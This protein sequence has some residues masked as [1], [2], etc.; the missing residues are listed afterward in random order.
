MAHQRR[1]ANHAVQRPACSMDVLECGWNHAEYYR[2]TAAA[3]ETRRAREAMAGSMAVQALTATRRSV[4]SRG[5]VPRP[6]WNA[7]QSEQRLNSAGREDR[8]GALGFCR[9]CREWC[10][11]LLP[12]WAARQRRE[13]ERLS[14]SAARPDLPLQF[15]F[16]LSRPT[17]SFLAGSK[18]RRLPS[19]WVTV[20]RLYPETAYKPRRVVPTPAQSSL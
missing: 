15:Q 4:P 17:R 13:G 10:T 8:Y 9:P 19:E 12:V 14:Q 6:P 3:G 18:Q 20:R 1:R 2:L 5:E 16:V 11:R 7:V